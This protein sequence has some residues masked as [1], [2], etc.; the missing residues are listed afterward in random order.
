MRRMHLP[1]PSVIAILALLIIAVPA[2]GQEGPAHSA[3]AGVTQYDA[4]YG[5]LDDLID[6]GRLV[7]TTPF[8][9][10]DGLGDGPFDATEYPNYAPG[11]RPTLQNDDTPFLRIN[12]LDAQSCN[13]CHVIVSHATRPPTLGIAGVG[14]VVNQA[15]IRPTM[16]DV[17][18]SQDNRTSYQAGH[19]P[20][21]PMLHN[22]VA[23]Y[24]GRFANPPFLFGSGGV[25]LLAKEM[26]AELQGRL[27]DALNAGVGTLTKLSA[28][29]VYFGYAKTVGYQ[30]V[31]LH[32]EGIGPVDIDENHPEAALVV[33]PFGRKGENF[34]VR[35]FDRGAMQFHF[36]VQPVEVVGSGV[37]GDG[38]T[39]F[40]EVTEGEMSVL[41]MFGVTNP[42]PVQ[43]R[44]TWQSAHGYRLFKQIGCTKCHKPLMRTNGRALPLA[45][46]EVATDP[47]QNVYRKIDLVAVGFTPDPFGHGV[48]VPLFSDLKRH[49]MG[50]RLAESLEYGGSVPYGEIEIPNEDFVTARLWGIADTAPYLHDGRAPTL[51]QAIEAHGGEAQVPRNN[52][53]GLSASDRND[54]IAFLKSLRTPG[55]VS[56]TMLAETP[57][58]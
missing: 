19:V 6:L 2:I 24:N 26:T 5:N 29:G 12:G 40:D 37:D 15:I 54:L 23:D 28:K 49:D 39:V 33:T 21:L 47:Y 10:Y 36:G 46:P 41:H 9:E 25:E 4:Q 57:V 13:E 1:I 11:N 3:T 53:L 38:D 20:D 45:H 58:E 14:G 16:A 35:D 30:Q 48:L 50:P 8:N 43:E 56:P 55:V 22:G 17:A 31:E 52:F 44:L 42:R 18:D 27:K 51:Y 34:S 7:F 32:L